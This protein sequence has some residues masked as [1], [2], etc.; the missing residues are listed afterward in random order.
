MSF[1]LNIGKNAKPGFLHGPNPDFQVWKMAGLP[2]FGGTWV[3]SPTCDS[4]ST[5]NFCLIGL[6]TIHTHRLGYGNGNLHGL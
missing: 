2:G 5:I 1:A 3:Y 4:I 6:F